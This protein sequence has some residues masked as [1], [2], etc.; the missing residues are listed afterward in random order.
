[1]LEVNHWDVSDLVAVCN[2]LT[3]EYQGNKEDLGVRI[4]SLLNDLELGGTSAT[5]DDEEKTEDECENDDDGTRSVA[6]KLNSF[7]LTFRQ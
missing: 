3:L 6:S 4:C 5:K 2:V 7:A 1:M